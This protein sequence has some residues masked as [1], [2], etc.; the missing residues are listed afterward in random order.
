MLLLSPCKKSEPYINP[1]LGFQQW[2]GE[3]NKKEE[4]D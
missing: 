2:W 4:E 3:K 1:L